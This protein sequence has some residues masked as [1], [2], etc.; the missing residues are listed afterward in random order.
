MEITTVIAMF[1][2]GFGLVGAALLVALHVA[3]KRI[4]EAIKQPPINAEPE[5]ERPNVPR[6]TYEGASVIEMSPEKFKELRYRTRMTPN[7]AAAY[8]EARAMERAEAAMKELQ[9]AS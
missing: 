2:L 3:S 4:V 8:Y 6:A 1:V 9:Y 7:E 5:P